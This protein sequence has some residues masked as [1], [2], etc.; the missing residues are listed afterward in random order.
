M[1]VPHK[2]EPV[3]GTATT[4]IIHS[5]TGEELGRFAHVPEGWVICLP[6]GDGNL[7]RLPDVFATRHAARRA[8]LE[9]HEPESE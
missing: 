7:V 1:S 4:R 2:C 6:G 5:D 9:A 8:I 3:K